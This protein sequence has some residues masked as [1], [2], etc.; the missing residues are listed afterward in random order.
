[1]YPC[2]EMPSFGTFVE[3]QVDSLRKEGLEVDVFF[4]NGRASRWNYLWSFP[5]L[6]A[7][8]LTHRYDLLH[9]HYVF[10]G[11]VAR[12]QLLRP[13]VLTQHGP[14]VFGPTYQAP[15]CRWVNPL[16]DRVI[17]VSEEQRVRGRLNKGTVIPC[18]IDFDLFKP[19]PLEETRRELGLPMDRKLILWAGEY[20]RPEKRFEVVQKSIELLRKEEPDVELVLVSGKPLNEVPKYMNAC[21]VLLLV[22]DGEGS[23]MVVK[24]AMACNLPVVS[25]PVGDVADVIGDTEGCFICSQDPRDVAEKLRLALS[26]GQRTDGREKIGHLEIGNIARRIIEVYEDLIEQKSGKGKARSKGKQVDDD[27]RVHV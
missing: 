1:M 24:E 17:T 10:S 14:E 18:G 3:K 15:L 16:M 19:M 6:W 27:R 22:S 8:L 7:R 20:F 11:I 21:D 25:V 12:A 13:V 23:P 2:P 5:R 26:R 9:A 4:F